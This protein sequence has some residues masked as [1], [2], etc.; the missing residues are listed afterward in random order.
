MLLANHMVRPQ[1][2]HEHGNQVRYNDYGGFHEATNYLIQL[3]HKHIWYIGDTSRPWFLNRYEGYVTAMAN[4]DLEPRAH[5]VALSDDP[6][7][8]GHA[9]VS[10]ILDQRW[11]LTA[12]VA[13]SDELAFG[14]REALR[15]NGR[16]IPHDVSLIGFENQLRRSHAANLT[17]VCVDMAEVG[18]QLAKMAISKVE[19]AGKNMAEVIVPAT[20]V[21]RSTC[22]PVRTEEAMVL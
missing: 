2:Q 14:A 10:Y 18:R 12:I 8:N 17:S 7:E 21:K 3:G 15:Q 5:T 9:A 19:S 11:P 1:S 20:L 6:Y 4:H 13:G 16:S 22:R